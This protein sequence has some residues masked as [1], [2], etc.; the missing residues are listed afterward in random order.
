MTTTPDWTIEQQDII[1]LKGRS[2]VGDTFT[3]IYIT[4]TD[5]DDGTQRE[6]HAD[7]AP[8]GLGLLEEVVHARSP[9]KTDA[10]QALADEAAAI[11]GGRPVH[12]YRVT[13]DG[14]RALAHRTGEKRP[15]REI[16]ERDTVRLPYQRGAAPLHVFDVREDEDGAVTLVAADQDLAARA[17]TALRLLIAELP[18]TPG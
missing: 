8:S 4:F 17:S 15:A 7:A 9:M 13:L 11:L 12:R 2:S 5:A 18:S 16:A 3:R 1:E 6:V 14:S 10:A